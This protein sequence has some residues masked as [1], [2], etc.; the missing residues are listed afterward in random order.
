MPAFSDDGRSLHYLQRARADRRFVSG[1]LWV[2]NVETG[3][4]ERL[5]PDFLMEHYDVARDGRRVVF[6]GIDAEGR[7][8]VWLATLDATETPRRLTSFDAVVRALF[9]PAG[10]VFLVGGERG[11]PYL[12]HISEDGTGLRRV[13]AHPVTF[14]YAVSPDGQAIA[15]WEGGDVESIHPR[16]GTG[17]VVAG[18]RRVSLGDVSVYSRDG[19]TRTPICADCAR[20]GGPERGITPPLVSWS[21]GGGWVYLMNAFAGQTFAV[22]LEP[23]RNLPALPPGGLPSMAAAAQLPGAMLLPEE[24]AFAGMDPSIYAFP[25]VTTHRNIYR[26]PVP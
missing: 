20:A 4:S 6:V 11:S 10:G 14:L 3:R 8:E 15:L 25:R 21:P 5:L 2:A 1:E 16:D 9:D 12:H 26:V 23:G 17:A 24:R 13:L 19:A 7:S 22:P 18:E